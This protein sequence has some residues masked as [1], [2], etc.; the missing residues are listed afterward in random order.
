MPLVVRIV[1]NTLGAVLVLGLGVFVSAK[2]RESRPETPRLE[3]VEV[4]VPVQVF[5][6]Q[7]ERARPR[8][9]SHGTV[10]PARELVLS[11]EVGGRIVGVHAQLQPG[12][13]LEAGEVA[14]RIDDRDHRLA[15][16]EA[17]SAV[18]QAEIR[19]RLEQGRQSVAAREWQL[20]GGEPGEDAS[21]ALREPQAEDARVQVEVARQR[22]DRARLQVERTQVRVPFT[23]L[24]RERS[25]DLGQLAV[26]GGVVARLVGVDHFWVQ[27]TLPLDVLPQIALPDHAGEGGARALVRQRSGE[28]E[29]ERVGCVVRVLGDADA[30]GRMARL[31][32]EVSDPLGRASGAGGEPLLLGSWVQV[33][34]EGIE[35]Q[36]VMRVPRRVLRDGGALFVMD[37]EDRLQVEAVEIA[38]READDVLLRPTL[39]EGVRVIQSRVPTAAPGLALR[40][41]QTGGSPTEE[42]SEAVEVHP[43]P[44]GS[45]GEYGVSSPPRPSSDEP[46]AGAGERP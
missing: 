20:Y 8:F 15:L 22:V 37:A 32:V 35:E 21:L 24:V 12:G 33:D 11:A 30:V 4:A 28:R 34:V 26:P 19:L 43:T 46:A 18:A 17:E 16:R 41:A 36:E 9:S 7:R 25:A 6:L 27:V 1:V 5:A 39:A 40:E 13:V 23:A 10:V 3:R 42:G 29:L 2:L 31:L 38:W 14:L 44:V 45:P